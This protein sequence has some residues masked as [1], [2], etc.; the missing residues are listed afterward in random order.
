MGRL[1]V[2]SWLVGITSVIVLASPAVASATSGD[3]LCVSAQPHSSCFSSIQSAVNQAS[4]GARI[5]V[6]SG[7]Y[8]EMVTITKRVSLIAEPGHA[9]IDATGKPQGILITGAGAA[10]TLVKGLSVRNALR[11]GILGQATSGLRIESNVVE[12]NDQGWVAPAAGQE[13]ATCPG[14]NPF[15]QDDCGEGLHF[16]GVSGSVIDSNVVQRNVGGILLTDEAAPTHDNL[17]THNTVQDNDRD[18]GITLPSHPA[19]FGPQGPLPGNG[20]YNN[21]VSDN[22]SRRNGGAGVGTFT[23]TP[24]TA[25]YNNIIKNNSLT[26]NGLPGVALHSHAF[27]QNL[28]GNQIIGNFIAGNGADDDANTGAP[29][30]IVI[31]ADKAGAAAPI[32]GMTIE[33]NTVLREAIDVWIGNV[34]ENLSLHRNNLLGAGKIGVDNTGTGI[35]DA[36]NNYWG[37]PQGPGAPGC[38]TVSGNVTFAP[39]LTQ[40]VGQH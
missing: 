29:T 32:S 9:V 8:A 17:V 16:N 5:Q 4:P 15:D 14:A 10:G 19:G 33:G 37:C 25:A 6:K 11:E 34:A 3:E 27:G 40:R 39:W 30:G 28:N 1:R 21:V 36:R 23:P 2:S 24:G 35:V 18:C 31:F 26:D 22:V 38:S 20:V 13:M 12:H 7:T